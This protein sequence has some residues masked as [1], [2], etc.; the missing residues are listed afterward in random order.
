MTELIRTQKALSEV[1]DKTASIQ[2][3]LRTL[4]QRLQTVQAKT[5]GHTGFGSDLAMESS[6][7]SEIERRISICMYVIERHLAEHFLHTTELPLSAVADPVSGDVAE[8]VY[9]HINHLGVKTTVLDSVM[10]ELED[11]SENTPRPRS[12]E[13]DQM[14]FD[15]YPISDKAS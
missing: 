15:M 6:A 2:S 14:L 9:R 13:I 5:N 7:L 4:K 11:L 3:S 12:R 10:M 8:K 1:F